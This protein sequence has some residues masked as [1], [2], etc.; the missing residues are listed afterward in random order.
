MDVNNGM[1]S[2]AV[3]QLV[4]Q[5][6]LIHMSSDKDASH[7]SPHFSLNP[8]EVLSPGF[9][10]PEFTYGLPIFDLEFSA[11]FPPDK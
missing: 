1:L 2:P 10:D 8:L 3:N 11:T 9:W 4:S 6:P 7:G 5:P